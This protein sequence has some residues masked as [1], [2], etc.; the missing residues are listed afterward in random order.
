MKMKV[1]YSDEEIELP[2]KQSK[3]S[4]GFFFWNFVGSMGTIWHFK[5]Y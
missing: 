1:L 5:L 3:Q 2:I 4:T